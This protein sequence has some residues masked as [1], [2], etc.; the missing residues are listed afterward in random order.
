[1][2]YKNCSSN[3]KL[4]IDFFRVNR[5]NSNYFSALLIGEDR[6]DKDRD[7]RVYKMHNLLTDTIDVGLNSFVD[8][9]YESSDTGSPENALKLSLIHI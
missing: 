5:T 8:N 1:M 6:K 4:I 3:P 7:E 2:C 9:R